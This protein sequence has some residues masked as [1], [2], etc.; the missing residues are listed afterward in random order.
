MDR[1][2]LVVPVDRPAPERLL[3]PSQAETS[4][5]LRCRVRDARERASSR[6]PQPSSQLSGAELLAACR[7]D[8]DA[9][10]SL[11]AAA[12]RHHLSGRGITRLMRVARTIADLDAA[13]AVAVPHIAEALGYRA[14]DRV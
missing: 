14:M 11:E 12:R 1:I 6:G 3:Q 13:H 10:R 4:E 8:A 5:S 7:F 2:D 9:R